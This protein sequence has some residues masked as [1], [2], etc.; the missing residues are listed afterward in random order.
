MGTEEVFYKSFFISTFYSV[1][2][3]SIIQYVLC[4]FLHLTYF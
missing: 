2:M 1:F 3:I 4:Y